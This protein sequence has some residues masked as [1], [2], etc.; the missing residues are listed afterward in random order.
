MPHPSKDT[1]DAS[2]LDQQVLD[3]RTKGKSFA[4]IAKSLKL[5]AARDANAAFLRVV[6]AAP[7]K[8]RSR[9][10]DEELG[11]LKLL[12]E[13]IRTADLAPFDRDKQLDVVAFLRKQLLAP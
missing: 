1:S 9:L 5:P 3:L 4:T 10:C 7:T 2:A 11:R 13:R 6:R 8:E 12:E